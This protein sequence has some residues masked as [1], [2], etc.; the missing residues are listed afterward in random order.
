MEIAYAKMNGP[1]EVEFDFIILLF[2]YY[3]FIILL[4]FY[5]FIILMSV[6][7]PVDEMFQL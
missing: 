3:Y 5:Y 2:Y 6:N 1:H 4:L 7:C